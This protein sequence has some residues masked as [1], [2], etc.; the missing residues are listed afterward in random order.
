MPRSRQALTVKE[1]WSETQRLNTEIAVLQTRLARY[2]NTEQ[3]SHKNLETEEDIRDVWN[4]WPYS[5]AINVHRRFSECLH[6]FHGK[7]S[8]M[9]LSWYNKRVRAAFWQQPHHEEITLKLVSGE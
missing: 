8:A 3:S 7:L 1:L 9:R 6:S 4:V 2:E 5:W